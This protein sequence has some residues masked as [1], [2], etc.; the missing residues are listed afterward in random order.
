M[1]N[2]KTFAGKKAQ[3]SDYSFQVDLK[4]IIRLLS[5]NLYSSEDVFLRELLQNSVDAVEAHKAAQPEF[6]DGRI[7]IAYHLEK[8]KQVKLVFSDNGI[9]LT[10][11][12]MHTFLSVIGQSSKRGEIKRGDFIGQFGIGLLSCF[13]VTEEI[14]V[15]SRSIDE[16]QVYCW[17]GKSDGTYQVTAEAENTE[18]ASPLSMAESGTEVTLLLKGKM[19]AKY[20]EERVVELLKTYGFLLKLPVEFSGDGGVR[21]INDAFIPWRQSFCSNEEI[22]RFGEMMFGE[23][24]FGVVPISGEGLK[25]YAFISQR[26]TSAAAAGQHKIFL[27]DMLITEDGKDLVPK[28][29]FFTRC[30][31]NAEDL[32]PMAS[33]E[34]FVLNHSLSKARSTIEQCI[35]DYFVALSQYDVNKLKHL[36]LIHNVA[37]KS[38]AVENEQI[39]KLF[40]PF[41]AFSTNKGSL[42][43]FQI[44]EAAKRSAVYYCM[45]VDEYRRARPMADNGNRILINA[46]YIY[47]TKLLQLLKRYQRGIHVEVFD[48][49]CYGELLEDPDAWMKQNLEAFMERA[50][51]VLA[52]LK[53]GAVLKQFEPPEVPALYVSWTDDFLDNAFSGDSSEEI[54]SG[55]FETFDFGGF[56]KKAEGLETDGGGFGTKL[57]LNGRN[58][59]LRRLAQMPDGEMMENMVRV[60]YVHAMLA[61]HYS[62]GEREM[63]ILNTGLIKLMEYGL[64]GME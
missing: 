53:C 20:S 14:F 35:F 46:G 1:D 31:L 40:F 16:D 4:G 64:G 3:V 43:G 33:R 30:I 49:A 36:T 57:Y 17:L 5:E 60:L 13:L 51:R 34:G 21:R 56:G 23:E 42:T 19:A 7:R 24:F 27:K 63:G 59:M 55:F 26:Q 41:L 11:E 48:E 50:R 28:W 8:P 22:L 15:R 6:T 39:Y 29:A 58:P 61:G 38:L 2:G 62:L 10:K 18:K 45:E 12:E 37:I 32:T 9:G 54:F 47:D 52:K 44:V 25:G